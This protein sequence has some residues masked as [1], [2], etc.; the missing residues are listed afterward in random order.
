MIAL[1]FVFRRRPEM[2]RE[3]CHRYWREH[4]GPLVA[5]HA[6]ALGV[7]RYVQARTTQHPLADAI[8]AGRAD[9]EPYDGLAALWWE[10][11]EE[12]LGA[13]S[14]PEARRAAEEL[15]ADERRFIDHARSALWLAEEHVLLDRGAERARVKKPMRLYFAFRRPLSLSLAEC[16]GYWLNRHGALVVRRSAAFPLRRYVQWHTAADAMNDVL[17]AGRGTL[18]PYDGVAEI[19]ADLDELVT[20]AAA[21][22]GQEAA[23]EFLADERRFIDPARSALW[24]AEER[25]VLA[26]A[27]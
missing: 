1:L 8:R 10:S 26:A 17:R 5:R 14:T 19:D 4:H 23:A 11:R 15:L 20:A 22:E 13:M 7:R 25:V 21:P 12:L 16:Q 9:E 24:L 2:G 6:G 27:G 18:E 3:E